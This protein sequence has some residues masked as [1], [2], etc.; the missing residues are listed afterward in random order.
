MVQPITSKQFH[1][2]AG[3]EDWRV[4]SDGAAGYF[5]TGSFA[6][7][8]EFVERIGALADAADHHPD[9]DLRYH[10]VLVKLSTHE[11]M[12]NGWLSERD[13]LLAAQ[14]SRAARELGISADPARVHTLQIAID[15]LDIPKVQAFWAAVLARSATEED[16]PDAEGAGP[17]F[18]FQQMDSERPQRNRIHIDL[19]VPAD[20]AEARIAAGVAAGGT[21]V[22]DNGPEWWT[23]ADPEGNEVDIAP[24]PDTWAGWGG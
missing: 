23:L 9:I 13:V 1:D 19:Y 20:Q 16:L 24:W 12:P 3:V 8:L 4:L 11:V 17:N 6:K 7:G 5:A 10:A 21:I 15:A 2:A 18:W 14:I 22:R